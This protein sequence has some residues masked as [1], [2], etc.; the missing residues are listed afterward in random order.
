[1]GAGVSEASAPFDGGR[2]ARWGH[3]LLPASLRNRIILFM[4]LG[5]LA[6]QGLVLGIWTHQLR[7]Q[8][9][10]QVLQTAGLLTPAVVQASRFMKALPVQYRPLLVDQLRTTG[11]SRF[12]MQF[13]RTLLP[14]PGAAS[15]ELPGMMVG[16]VE[17][18][19]GRELAREGLSGARVHL[20]P[21]DRLIVGDDRTTLADLP[22]RWVEASGLPRHESQPVL[23]VQTSLEP[24]NWLLL[25][26][27]LPN[28]GLFLQANPYAPDRLL[29]MF[30]GLLS[31]L[32]VMVVVARGVTRSLARLDQAALAFARDLTVDHI[33]ERGPLEVRRLAHSF[34]EMQ[35][36]IQRNIGDRETLFRSVSH[37]LKTPIMR[38]GFRTELLDDPEL[39]AGFKSDLQE[40]GTMLQ[41]ALTTMQGAELPEATV[42][43]PLDALLRSLTE[44]ATGAGAPLRLQ[45]L[46]L[47]VPGKPLALKRALGNLIDNALRYGHSVEVDMAEEAGF[48]VIR[49]RDHGPG[50][51]E[52]ALERIFDPYLRLDHG[53]QANSQGNGLGLWIARNA[54]RRHGGDIVLSNHPNGGLLARVTLRLEAR[55]AG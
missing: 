19:L 50:L 9:R 12:L 37:D 11:G 2:L 34:N 36:Q 45:T 49:I 35:A 18:E 17:E 31:V 38:L 42:A 7:D 33:P 24:G 25:A 28:P 40:I 5:A 23:V 30:A 52:A 53:R 8:A 41:G 43:V 21:S 16:L 55:G 39:R 22:Q 13:N 20:V 48:A 26:S 10:L 3:R 32:L 14:Q 27:A 1:M 29:L 51:P 47:T 44:A 6:S 4:L 15:G 54:V 46:P